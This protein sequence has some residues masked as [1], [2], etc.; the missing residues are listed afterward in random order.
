MELYKV[1]LPYGKK[2]FYESKKAFDRYWPDNFKK[3][4]YGSVIVYKI[5]WKDQDW[6]CIRHINKTRIN[7]YS[8]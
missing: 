7:Y 3:A 4:K 1:V 8:K 6:E 2:K 5:N